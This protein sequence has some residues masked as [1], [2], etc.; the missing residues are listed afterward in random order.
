MVLVDI[1]DSKDGVFHEGV[2]PA[3]FQML[4]PHFQIMSSNNNANN[5]NNQHHNGSL[6]EENTSTTSSPT[7]Q[8][9]S[10]HS[11]STSTTASPSQQQNTKHTEI[12]TTATNQ[13]PVISNTD[14][15]NGN[16]VNETS[17]RNREEVVVDGEGK[18]EM[19]GSN[20]GQ[21]QMGN[22]NNEM[23]ASPFQVVIESFSSQ[24]HHSASF[25][26]ALEYCERP[27]QPC[28]DMA[29]SYSSSSFSSHHH[30]SHPS[31][32]TLSV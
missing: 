4:P 15:D 31:N 5:N 19:V 12:N 2:S 32:H 3:N 24:H 29:S 23:R 20:E 16:M 28:S 30:R 25:P 10:L 26:T 6:E 18:A 14:I 11:V 9:T 13:P 1:G 22:N 21:N 17:I 27:N 8:K 7:T